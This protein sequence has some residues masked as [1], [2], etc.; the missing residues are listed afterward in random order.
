MDSP[1][2]ALFATVPQ[3]D[4]LL[5]WQAGRFQPQRV[6]RFLDLDKPSLGAIAGVASS[7][8]R[9]DAKI[10][11]QLSELLSELA[12]TA[13]FVAEFFGGDAM[14]TRLWF[15]TRNPMLGDVSPRDMIRAGRRE[16]LHRFVLEARGEKAPQG[17]AGQG[18]EGAV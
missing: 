10:P 11:K 7:S 14:K 17:G 16:Q 18:S 12:L 15:Q 9:F 6:A 13:T 5:F 4:Y 8:V 1:A 2:A 3:R